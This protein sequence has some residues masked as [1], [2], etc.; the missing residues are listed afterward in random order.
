M[1]L[2]IHQARTDLN[3]AKGRK[4]ELED[5]IEQ[6][7]QKI[8]NGK[9]TLLHVEQAH[10]I[11]KS[12]GLQTQQ[13]LRY[14]IADIASMALES[15]FSQPYK[16]VLEFVESRG[17]NECNI[18][19]ERNG[20]DF[21]PMEESGGGVVDLA[22]FALRLASWSMQSPRSRACIILN[23]PF[24]HLSKNLHDKA[25]EMIKAVSEK[26]HVQFIIITHEPAL[27]ACADKVFT[28]TQKRKIS[29]IKSN[30]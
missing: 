11:L 1:K 2:T 15:V 23:E 18:L 13:Q 20:V 24:K 12:V 29:K 6:I 16:L 4:E 8:K 17:K 22:A 21:D 5:H 14:H 25:S 28:V 30:G 7:H 26:L 3:K 10:E 19:F 9:R 27:G